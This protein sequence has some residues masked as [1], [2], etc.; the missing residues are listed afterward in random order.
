M[1]TLVAS[2][3]L[4]AARDL[5]AAFDSRRHP[6]RVL[7]RFLSRYQRDL[8]DRLV[9][10]DPSQLVSY[11]DTALPLADFASGI[12]I[13]AYHYP[14]GAEI[15]GGAPNARPHPIPLVSWADHGR[16]HHAVY[17][18]DGVLYLTGRA[19]WWAR[20]VNLRWMYVPEVADLDTSSA[21]AP[22]QVLTSLPD[23]AEPTL[24][25]FLA[26]KMAQRGG[27]DPGTTAPDPAGLAAEWKME[28]D[29]FFDV[30]GRN[31]QAV[32]S[33]VGDVF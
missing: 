8:V 6:D 4:T 23:S 7:L 12:T 15:T 29:R 25:A 17:L 31:R 14:M 20:F 13:P 3:I 19:E 16:H 26:A 30:V 22:A 9:R 28:E 24:V 2:A 10:L 21:A 5:S 33:L 1:G 32:S 11:Q 27:A 18:L